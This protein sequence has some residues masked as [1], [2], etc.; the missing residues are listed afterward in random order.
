MVMMFPG[1][2]GFAGHVPDGEV[3]QH[4]R[5]FGYVGHFCEQSM[6][7]LIVEQSVLLTFANASRCYVMERGRIVISG[8]SPILAQDEHV[9]AIVR[10]TEE[11][12]S[13]A[14]TS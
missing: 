6:A 9:F 4:Y 8:D 5:S 12:S 10:G 13:P 2:R 14:W 1:Q 3:F 7:N 11:V